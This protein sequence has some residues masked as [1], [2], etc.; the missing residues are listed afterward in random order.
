M[1]DIISGTLYLR[2][3]AD[4]ELVLPIVREKLGPRP[5]LV[6]VKAPVCRPAW[7]VEL[8]CIAVNKKGDSKYPPLA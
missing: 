1:N 3:Y 8:E 2:D 4:A 6:T 5:V 7:L